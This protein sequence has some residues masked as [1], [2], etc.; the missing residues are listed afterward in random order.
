ME[1]ALPRGPVSSPLAER[2]RPRPDLERDMEGHPIIAGLAEG[3]FLTR[4]DNR[5]CGREELMPREL[6]LQLL[7]FL[8]TVALIIRWTLPL[9]CC[10]DRDQSSSWVRRRSSFQVFR[11]HLL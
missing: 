10:L 1:E 7:R 6:W 9:H 11:Q 4:S 5:L 8:G 2:R 3:L